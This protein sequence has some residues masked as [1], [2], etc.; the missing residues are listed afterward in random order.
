M[1]LHGW[2]GAVQE[3][4]QVGRRHPLLQ[5]LPA[6]GSLPSPC[7]RLS[8]IHTAF[9]LSLSTDTAQQFAAHQIALPGANQ[10]TEPAG[11]IQPESLGTL[12]LCK[13]LLCK[14]QDRPAAA[15]IEAGRKRMGLLF[16]LAREGKRRRRGGGMKP[17]GFGL[18]C[19]AVCPSLP[20]P[21]RTQTKRSSS[22]QSPTHVTYRERGPIPWVGMTG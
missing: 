7:P 12:R 17:C 16:R 19:F 9:S 13:T 21:C 22:S 3:A 14:N 18:L 10:E 6:H 8:S 5:P 20:L 2:G 11:G 4:L 1:R 15:K